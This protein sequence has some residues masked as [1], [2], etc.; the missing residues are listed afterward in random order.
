MDLESNIRENATKV[1]IG[2]IDKILYVFIL[3]N[4]LRLCQKMCLFLGYMY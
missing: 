1:I 3:I 4:V 2:T